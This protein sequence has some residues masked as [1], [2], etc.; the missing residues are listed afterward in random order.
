MAGEFIWTGIDY[1]GEP[2]PYE[3]PAKSSYFGAIDTANFP[4]DVFYFYQ[5]KW[6]A[7]GPTMVHIVP[8]NWT[9]WTN[10]QSVKALV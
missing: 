7:S 3:W 9:N 2:T 10:G 5:S 1:I 8:T 6:K 4:K